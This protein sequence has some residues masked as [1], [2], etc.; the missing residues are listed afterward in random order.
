MSLCRFSL[1]FSL[2]CLLLS[3]SVLL[4][5]MTL[6]HNQPTHRVF[7]MCA[8][9]TRTCCVS[10]VTWP[11][12]PSHHPN[13]AQWPMSCSELWYTH[14]K[15]HRTMRGKVTIC[16]VVCLPVRG[17]FALAHTAHTSTATTCYTSLLSSVPPFLFSTH[18]FL[19]SSL[20]FLCLAQRFQPRA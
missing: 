2:V 1:L 6:C 10:C 7:V 18:H 13:S 9:L 16:V 11:V 3:H 5:R 20:L 19:Y 14:K 4:H 8:R 12:K 15:H 17:L